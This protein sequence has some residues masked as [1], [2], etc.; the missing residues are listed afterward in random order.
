MNRGV[1]NPQNNS[2]IEKQ[3]VFVWPP[4]Y[5]EYFCHKITL[6]SCAACELNVWP[7][8]ES[9]K[10]G[11][12]SLLFLKKCVKNIWF[13]Y[14][15]LFSYNLLVCGDREQLHLHLKDLEIF[16]RRWVIKNLF[17]PKFIGIVISPIG[18]GYV[19]N[20]GRNDSKIFDKSYNAVQAWLITSKQ[21]VPETSS[22]FGWYILFIKPILGDLKNIQIWLIF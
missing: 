3:I 1:N 2:N 22:I 13:T 20:W 17:L 4:F 19:N 12:W 11:H 6:K 10:C 5:F 16:N 14:R 7:A 9:S 21:T 18:F 8:E 15:G